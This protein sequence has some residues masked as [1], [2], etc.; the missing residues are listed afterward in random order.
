M[1]TPSEPGPISER[2]DEPA[3]RNRAGGSHER[4]GRSYRNPGG[5][6][7]ADRSRRPDRGQPEPPPFPSSFPPPDQD[8]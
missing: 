5:S 6:H 7:G 2:P 8:P 3:R 1:S 4:P